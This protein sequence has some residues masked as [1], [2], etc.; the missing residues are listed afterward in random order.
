MTKP[1]LPAAVDTREVAPRDGLQIEAPIPT[2][3]KVR[4]LEALAATG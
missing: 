4:L 1:R 3:A 2:P